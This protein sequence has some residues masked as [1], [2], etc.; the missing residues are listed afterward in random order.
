M[1]SPTNIAI[2]GVGAVCGAGL[3]VDEIWNAIVNGK[4]AI[5]PIEQWDASR[6]PVNISAE[7]RNVENRTLVEDRKLHKMISRT[8][9]FGL[10]AANQAVQQ[11]GL[12]TYHETLDTAAKPK[13]N[14][15]TGVFAGSGGGNYRSN[16]DYLPAMS[17][18]D[19]D[20]KKFGGEFSSS[21]NP[22]WLLKNLPNNVL[23]HVGIRY[24]FKGTNA[25]VT[26]QC[27][28]GVLAIAEAAAALRNDEADRASATG[29]DT[30]FEPETVSGY[31]QLGLLSR[32]T[33]RPFDRDR[34]GTVFGEGAASVVLEKIEDA[35]ARGAKILGEFLG[36]GC[37]TEGAGILDLR[38]DGDGVSRAIEL[39]LTDAGI[40][41]AD[42]GLIVAHGN[43]TR[44][45]DAS[46]ALGIRRVFGANVPP[47]TAFKWAVGHL[48]AASGA[49]DLVLALR[50]LR[51][52]IA[53]GI[54]TLKVID[55]EVS[56]LPVS[57]K[58]QTPRSDIA[59]VI[60]RGFG[61]MNVALI[62]QTG[63]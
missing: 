48:I 34:S 44:A 2:T 52:K 14:D 28:G 39:A 47:V 56:P 38:P 63:V 57:A 60:C 20:L 58:A 41:A 61:G 46:E 43:G 29:H 40:S 37:V 11:S 21:V 31:H 6:W 18:G 42:V 25:C 15:R 59:L 10:F 53:P 3:S 32:D 9:M 12:L 49:L 7:V 23:C 22:M 16:Y 55:P 24:G 5:A 35:K 8:D 13:F 33:L 36:C 19:G 45:S 51:E 50:A 1:G 30:P 17:A 26:N 54:A 27:V 62:V 4:S